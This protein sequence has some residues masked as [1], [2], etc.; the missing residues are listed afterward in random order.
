MGF[1]PFLF[2]F[3]LPCLLLTVLQVVSLIIFFSVASQSV[4]SHSCFKGHSSKGGWGGKKGYWI[5]QTQN[6]TELSKA[7][8]NLHV[9]CLFLL[10]KIPQ[11]SRNIKQ[12]I[13]PLFWLAVITSPYINEWQKLIILS[14]PVLMRNAS[15]SQ[16]VT[17]IMELIRFS[18]FML[19]QTLADLIIL[20][21]V[22]SCFA[23][24]QISWTLGFYFMR[25][26]L[27]R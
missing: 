21:K 9:R 20:L 17:Q 19:H 11:V 4:S 1:L 24:K 27:C 12:G 25:R 16:W 10:A 13:F 5:G 6:L 22:F 14:N 2:S 18:P 8:M 15:R 3:R 26:L 7:M 23:T